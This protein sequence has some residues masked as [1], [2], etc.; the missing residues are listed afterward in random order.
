V[1]A[2]SGAG[3]DEDVAA[4]I[5]TMRRDVAAAPE[6]YR[7]GNFWDELIAVNL[8][9][10]R[11]EGIA[12]LK[13]TVSNNY[14]NW[15]VTRPTDPQMRRAALGWLKRPTLAPLANR[16]EEPASGLR[17]PATKR[18]FSL[19][20]VATWPYKFFVGALWE[21]AR[22]EDGL[23]LTERLSEPEVGNPIRIRHR[24][25]LISQ[26]LANSIIEFSFAARS[27]VLRDGCRVAELGAGYGRLAHV[28]AEACAST[29]CIFDIPPALAVSQWYLTAV[30]GSER[31][32]PYASGNDFDAVESS[33]KPGT[34]A[35]FTPD[36]M[37]TFPDGWFDCTQTIS[38]L[39]EM[40]AEQARHYLA[41]LSSK[42]GRALF[43]KQ[44]MRWHN[45]ADDAELTEQRYAVPQPW[46][47]AARRVDPIQP[48]FF[49]HL[50]LR[51]ELAPRAIRAPAP[52]RWPRSKWR[53]S[54]PRW[55]PS[56][57]E[58]RAPSGPGERPAR[59][60]M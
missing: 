5:A 26:D 58:P 10:L 6:I 50:W 60:A 55:R 57:A 8:E 49:N 21:T 23:G 14:Y 33:L 52:A 18:S 4:L 43:L 48:A 51:P 15:L 41:L 16:L 7:P 38:T 19:S 56:S 20:R 25:R 59:A 35:F 27:G 24:G 36:Q 2:P 39:P 13:R 54:P 46:R 12:N 30:L 44:W 3:S 17:S 53:Q 11:T 32:V 22:R 47:L 29:Y 37:E 34:V 9:M 31:I 42:S 1:P 40:P 45:A 28:F